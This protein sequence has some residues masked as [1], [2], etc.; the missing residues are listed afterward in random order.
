MV[1][2]FFFCI[3]ASFFT[4]SNCDVY[5]LDDIDALVVVPGHAHMPFHRFFFFFLRFYLAVIHDVL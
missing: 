2:F 5:D 4:H 1:F 3:L